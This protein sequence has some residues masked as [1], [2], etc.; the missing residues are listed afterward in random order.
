VQRKQVRRAAQYLALRNSLKK[1]G[2]L[3]NNADISSN[4]YLPAIVEK[5]N[6]KQVRHA[7]YLPKSSSL[8]LISEIYTNKS[9]G[10]SNQDIIDPFPESSSTDT[11]SEYIAV[12]HNLY[13]DNSDYKQPRRSAHLFTSF[14]SSP[15]LSKKMLSST[16]N[17]LFT[18]LSL[19]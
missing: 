10:K 14:S 6:K 2:Q 9:S 18:H 1:T 7:A 19:S 8:S 11:S 15:L 4:N 17:L 3:N 12:D 13:V 16:G 5:D